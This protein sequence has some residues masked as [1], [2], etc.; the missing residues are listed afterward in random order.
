MRSSVLF[1]GLM[2]ASCSHVQRAGV[3][4]EEPRGEERRHFGKSRVEQTKTAHGDVPFDAYTLSDEHVQAADRELIE[5][6]AHLTA[7]K[8]LEAFEDRACVGLSGAERSACP[9]FASR[10]QQVEWA[11]DGFTLTFKQASDAAQ[12][13][14]RLRC[15]LAY[16]VSTG[17]DRPSCPLFIPGTT[18]RPRGTDG[19]TFSG[20]SADVASALRVAARRIFP[21]SL[22]TP[23][24][25]AAGP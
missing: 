5:A 15:H 6:S 3:S 25:A 17:F 1:L 8:S 7:A 4:T 19:I 21:A 11:E 18:L 20:D 10:V 24:Q 12:T 22:M 9:L 13:Y 23:R 14:P 16:A 2:L